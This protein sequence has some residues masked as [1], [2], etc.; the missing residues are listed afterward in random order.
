MERDIQSEATLSSLNIQILSSPAGHHVTAYLLDADSD[1]HVLYTEVF[2][3]EPPEGYVH[4]NMIG[5]ARFVRDG[6]THHASFVTV[7]PDW[8][9]KKV[10]SR[11]YDAIE[12]KVGKIVPASTQSDDAIAFWKDRCSISRTAHDT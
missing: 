11:M 7:H 6:D 4:R 9:R 10:A 1:F 2:L 12:A 3:L 8:R 5:Y